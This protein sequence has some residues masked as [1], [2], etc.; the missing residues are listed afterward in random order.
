M[1]ETTAAYL[2]AFRGEHLTRA[3]R[4]WAADS[5]EREEWKDKDSGTYGFRAHVLEG[6][7]AEIAD[8]RAAPALSKEVREA[9]TDAA[10]WLE[11]PTLGAHEDA[12]PAH[13]IRC[14]HAATLRS[15]L[16]VST[17]GK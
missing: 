9:L 13:C 8:L 10:R 12:L 16:A 1:S 3:L 15:F 11:S 7:L 17:E 6:A 14:Q 5:R 4:E 2:A